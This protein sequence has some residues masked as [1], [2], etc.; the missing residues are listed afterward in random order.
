[1][2]KLRV[3]L[4]FGGISTEHE[5]SVTSATN[6]LQALDPGRYDPVLIG[7]DHGG[8]WRVLEGAGLPPEAVFESDEAAYA[9]PSLREGLEFL[10]GDGS[11]ALSRRLD[12]VF[13]IIHGRGGEDGSLQ[14]LFEVCSI[15]YVGAGVLSTALCMDKT[16]SKR[17]LRDVGI[18]VLPSHEAS[19]P[20]VLRDPGE[21]IGRVERDFDYPVFVKPSNTG[22]S[23]GVVRAADR[24]ELERGIAEAARYDH[25]VLVEQGVDAREV[26]CA[27]LGGHDPE[28]SVLGEIGYR[29]EF[30]DYEAKYVS[31]ST[32]L[33][34]PA[35]LADALSEQVRS[36]AVAAFCALK[37]WGLARVDF[38]IDRRGEQVYLNELN[39]LPGF[40][41]GSMYP[42]LWEASGIAPPELV[43]RLI[44]LALERRREQDA[45]V[46]RYET[47]L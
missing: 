37:C 14:G 33:V 46:T 29:G 22:S 24:A 47:R 44:E 41:D 13:P 9:F 17:A 39:T 15:P 30:Y 19:R 36:L 40:T 3:A 25:W 12:V 34:I 35:P 27:V 43:D 7:L 20:E 18:P 32:E 6:I 21:L 11:S 1:V 42:R 31:D 23:V 26:E 38:F 4:L 45:L 28:G 5:V 2:S 16:L 10:T 8:L